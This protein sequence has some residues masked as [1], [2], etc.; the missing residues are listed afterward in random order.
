MIIS[1]LVII[2]IYYH[3]M[4]FRYKFTE[5]FAK[6]CYPPLKNLKKQIM[7]GKMHDLSKS[8]FHLSKSYEMI[9]GSGDAAG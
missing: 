4:A 3:V 5:S 9:F 1:F 7:R 6:T 8:M 2:D